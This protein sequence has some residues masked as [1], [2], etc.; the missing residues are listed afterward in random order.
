MWLYPETGNKV[1]LVLGQYDGEQL[2]YK[3]HVTLGVSLNI[4]SQYRYMERSECPFD[5]V[6]SENKKAVWLDP[7][8]VCIIEFMPTEK[9]SF[10]QPVFKGI[11]NDK[12]AKECIVGNSIN[13]VGV[14]GGKWR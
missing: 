14:N 8:L 12:K 13:F 4:L 11:R 10:R 7:E 6:P 9:E 2:V 3:G 1:S 5:Y